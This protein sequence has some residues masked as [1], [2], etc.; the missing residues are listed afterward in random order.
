MLV[1][2]SVACVLGVCIMRSCLIAW[3]RGCDCVSVIVH[4]ACRLVC[5]CEFW[6]CMCLAVCTC[7]VVS[8]CVC[9]SWKWW[10]WCV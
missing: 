6:V 10:L 8:V 4:V 5:V 7:L 2:A 1:C 3:L 9:V